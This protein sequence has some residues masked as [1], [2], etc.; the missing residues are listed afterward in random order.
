[1]RSTTDK[2][3]PTPGTRWCEVDDDRKKGSK[4]LVKSSCAIPQPE[5]STDK[6][7]GPVFPCRRDDDRLPGETVLAS[8]IQQVLDQ[9]TQQV[10][11]RLDPQRALCAR[12]R[13]T[14]SLERWFSGRFS[15]YF[16][17]QQFRS[18]S[19]NWV[20]VE[21]LGAAQEKK[22][23]DDLAKL[24]GPLMGQMNDATI[25]LAGT[26]VSLSNFKVPDHHRDRCAQLMRRLAA[27]PP[28]TVV[29]FVEPGQE[30]VKSSPQVV[31]LIASP[32]FGQSPAGVGC[33]ETLAPIRPAW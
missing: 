30:V 32:N 31:Q 23:L 24:D 9:L 28:L 21:R 2:P 10:R 18:R 7:G 12:D 5:S 20:S 19:S 27:E 15:R 16:M 4:I 17:S 6:Q 1:M 14:I 33:V 3:S 13:S 22:R 29:R 25:L 26:L 11:L 8:V